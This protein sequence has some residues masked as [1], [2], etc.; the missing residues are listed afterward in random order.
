M[1]FLKNCDYCGKKIGGK[2]VE[3]YLRNFC[4]RE[5]VAGYV[6]AYVEE[7][8]NEVYWADFY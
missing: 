6:G 8:W 5:H 4:S 1:R 2:P 7:D 3:R